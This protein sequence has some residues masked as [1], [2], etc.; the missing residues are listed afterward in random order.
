MASSPSQ[1]FAAAVTTLTFLSVHS[2][3]LPFHPRDVLP[4]LPRQIS[5]PILNS[6]HG[7]VDLLPTFVGSASSP[8]DSFEWKGACFYQN[9]AWMEFHNKTGSEF[10]GG[11]LHLKVS[12][13]F[14]GFY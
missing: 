10:G 11:T 9:T 5:W 8:N 2:V 4:L 3:K 6:L 14:L 1:L 13:Q 12:D 7:A